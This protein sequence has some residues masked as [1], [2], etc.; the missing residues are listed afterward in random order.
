MFAWRYPDI[1]GRI[2]NLSKEQ[3]ETG[4]TGGKEDACCRVQVL[5]YFEQWMKLQR[6]HVIY[7]I[8]VGGGGEI[9]KI[10]QLDVGEDLEDEG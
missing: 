6:D 9:A 8:E 7:I 2:R 10:W 3:E 4:G 1:L 5:L